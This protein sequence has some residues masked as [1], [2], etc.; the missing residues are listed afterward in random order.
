[1]GNVVKGQMVVADFV[2]RGGEELA[3]AEIAGDPQ[4]S[5]TSCRCGGVRRLL[6]SR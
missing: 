2:A 6:V 1:M 5:L 3:D 4:M